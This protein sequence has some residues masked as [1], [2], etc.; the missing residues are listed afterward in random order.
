[1][2]LPRLLVIALLAGSLA[3][4]SAVSQELRPQFGSR[5]EVARVQV[6]VVDEEGR[7][8]PGLTPED[9]EVRVAGE[10][11]ELVDLMAV[12]VPEGPGSQLAAREMEAATGGPLSAEASTAGDS[13]TAERRH[14]VVFLDLT[15]INRNA[16]RYTKR[17]MADFLDRVVEPEDRVGLAVYSPLRGIVW[18]VP[19]TSR[20]E[21]LREAIDTLRVS[22][23]AESLDFGSDLPAEIDSEGFNIQ[24]LYDDFL[25]IEAQAML[26][27][28]ANMGED[29]AAL[30]A[31]KHLVMLSRGYAD[32]LYRD[33]SYVRAID[34]LL[35]RIR[36]SDVVVHT[37]YPDRLPETGSAIANRSF[38]Y[39]VAEETGG[40][41]T[42][43]QHNADRG[44]EEVDR[45]TR[46]YYVLSIPVRGDDPAR[47]P[48]DIRLRRPGAEVLWA[49]IEMRTP[50][51]LREL[52]ENQ[53]QLQVAAALD[54]GFD[55]DLMGFDLRVVP[56]GVEAGLG[57][58]AVLLQMDPDEL[59]RLADE[60]GDGSLAF[61][62]L[63]VAM[64]RGG[65]ISDVFRSRLEAADRARDAIAVGPLRYVGVFE[66]PPGR[67]LFKLLLRE[68]RLGKLSARSSAF[69]VPESPTGSL[70]ATGPVRVLSPGAADV[71][72]S[73]RITDDTY[74]LTVT[75]RRL[76]PDLS[77]LVRAG[78]ANRLLVT[79]ANLAGH[80]FTGR[81]ELHAQAWITLGEEEPLELE[82]VR[83][84]GIEPAAE[85]GMFRALVEVELPRLLPSGEAVLTLAFTD[86]INGNTTTTSMSLGLLGE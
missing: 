30:E 55:P 51:A 4:S 85:P 32:S 35:D 41:T 53:R 49:P 78:S 50:E 45:A 46:S 63:G 42:W 38:L 2:P 69:E 72:R 16:M 39:Q 60:R 9:F 11:R 12:T 18:A 34:D 61:E 68:E 10:V 76:V 3:A 21:L 31:R 7:F 54:P 82:W 8:L 24:D 64:R 57:R 65:Q 83:V 70:W 81:Y 1:M 29:L 17:I 80:P 14:F 27:A 62:L 66:A 75:G 6:S 5:V 71:A 40:T 37:L 25:S 15:T 77:P 20:H 33:P 52:T 48:L 13:R 74:P 44:I 22:Q 79:L 84:T 43:F 19:L 26:A 58:F 56:M 86:A 28:L 36:A 23:A 67:G 47:L 73:A 59:Q